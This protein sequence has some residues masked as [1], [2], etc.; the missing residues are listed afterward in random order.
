MESCWINTG[1][2][3]IE[4][5]VLNVEEINDEIGSGSAVMNERPENI[6]MRG[7]LKFDEPM[8][9][10]TSWR[11]G[12][13]ADRFYVPADIEDLACFLARLDAREPCIWMGLGSNLLVRDGGIRGTVIVV[14]GIL[15]DLEPSGPYSI[16]AGA[17]VACNKFARFAADAGLTGV[18][19]MAGIPGTVGGALTMNAGAF[20]SETWDRVVKTETLSRD[21][22]LRS[23]DRAEFEV[24]YRRVSLPVDEWFVSAEFQLEPDSSGQARNRIRDLLARR[25]AGQ[26]T[27]ESSCGSVFRN[28]E[29]DYAGRIIDSC[30]LKGMQIG[31]ARV[32]GKHANFIINEGGASATDIEALILYVQKTVKEK[33]GIELETEVRIVGEGL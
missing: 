17:G 25:A 32:S 9:R 12:G 2:V 31:K 11:A 8:A 22:E 27:G 33:T 4:V 16:K 29:A 6:D 28:P 10:H 1:R 23:R 14:A 7:V 3:S 15:A 24:G 21:G 19:F 13:T 20:G 18:E 5:R 26:P 30:G